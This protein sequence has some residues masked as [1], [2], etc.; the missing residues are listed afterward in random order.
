[1]KY[2]DYYKVLGV[3]KDA[4]Q[5]EIKKAYRK[6]A[7]KYHPDKNPGDSASEEKFKELNEAN[8]VLSD[9]EK[10]KK[11]DTLGADWENYQQGNAQSWQG[12]GGNQGGGGSFHFEGDPSEFFGSE[13]EFSDFFEQFFGG[14]GSRGRRGT[15][16]RSTAFKG[17]DLEAKLDITLLEAYQGASRIFKL[18]GD[19]I[20]IKIKP[21][22]RHGQKLRIKGKGAPGINGGPSGD[23][24][25]MLSLLQDSKFERKG[26]DLMIDLNVGLYEAVLGVKQ[27]IPT[28]TGH[29]KMKIPAN[30]V[31]GKKLRLKGK[32]MPIYNK[33]GKYGDLL[34]RIHIQLP[35]KLSPEELK[36]F[37]ELNSMTKNSKTSR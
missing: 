25:I 36:L 13:S 29:V 22:V 6:L 8:E 32:G 34:A 5:K 15:R 11:Y 17:N 4:S 20:R 18:H 9:P 30:F 23:L 19:S 27:D 2:K 26:D 12:Q 28:M 24:Y 37:E 35:G 10:R 3:N 14:A 31:S 1:M 21:G 16:Q 7:A 33:P